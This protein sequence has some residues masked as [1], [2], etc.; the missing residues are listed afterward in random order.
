MYNPKPIQCFAISSL[1]NKY[2]FYKPIKFKVKSNLRPHSSKA[3]S[4]LNLFYIC[5]FFI[6]DAKVKP[7]VYCPSKSPYHPINDACWTR[8]EKVPYLAFARTLELV[9][10]TSS[11]LK[12][13]EIVANFLRSLVVL[14][15][16]DIVPALRM[17]INQLAPA[18]T[19]IW[20]H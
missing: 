4:V 7:E 13:I 9:E 6:A 15:P 1:S 18:Y 5:I 10:A 8:E 12:S 11:R 19:G 14:S 16:D 17:C 20:L 3:H 2:T